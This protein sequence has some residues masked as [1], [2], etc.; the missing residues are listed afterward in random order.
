MKYEKEVDNLIL[1]ITLNPSVDIGYRLTGNLNLNEVN[2]VD[3]VSKTSGGKGLNV[4]RVLKQLNEDVAATGFLGGS[5]AVFI[6]DGIGEE[7]IKDYVIS[8]E[9]ATRNYIA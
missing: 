3:N 7:G 1:T 9:E 6:H 8:I 2:R 4:S 5:L